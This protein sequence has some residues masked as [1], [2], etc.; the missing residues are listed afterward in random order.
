MSE[1]V[2]SWNLSI[3]Q[4]LVIALREAGLSVQC[5]AAIPVWFRRQKIGDF[6]TDILVEKLVLLEL[7]SARVLDS[8]MRLN[9]YII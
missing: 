9:C 8:G 5:Q 4:A 2:D 7:K 1:V 3:K 6:R